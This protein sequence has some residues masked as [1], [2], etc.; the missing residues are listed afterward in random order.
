MLKTEMW[1]FSGS[2]SSQPGSMLKCIL[3]G[4]YSSFRLQRNYL[5]HI[6]ETSIG[7]CGE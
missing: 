7:P 5:R 1:E 4:D 2:G 6:H 3:G